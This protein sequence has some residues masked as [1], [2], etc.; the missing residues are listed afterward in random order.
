MQ[1]SFQCHLGMW[2][3]KAEERQWKN[4]IYPGTGVGGSYLEIFPD[5]IHQLAPALEDPGPKAEPLLPRKI[6]LAFLPI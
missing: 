4:C 6:Q 1:V 2:N 5:I 3:Q